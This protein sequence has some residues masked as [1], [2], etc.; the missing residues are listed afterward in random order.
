MRT[1]PSPMTFEVVR[2]PMLNATTPRELC[3][4]LPVQMMSPLPKNSQKKIVYYFS[5]EQSRL[6]GDRAICGKVSKDLEPRW[7]TN[8]HPANTTFELLDQNIQFR[9]IV[10]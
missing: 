6:S 7:K 8:D 9:S 1:S 5:V 4:C 2:N 10:P 3:L